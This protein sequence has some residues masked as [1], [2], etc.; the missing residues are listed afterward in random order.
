MEDGSEDEASISVE[1]E[2]GIIADEKDEVDG[3]EKNGGPDKT[4][5][6]SSDSVLA[7]EV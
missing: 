2:S 1:S 4:L 5:D 3:K 7:T 6:A